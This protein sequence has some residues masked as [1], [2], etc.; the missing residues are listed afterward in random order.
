M[1]FDEQSEQLYLEKLS[2]QI[3][4]IIRDITSKK[5]ARY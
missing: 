1:R 2:R 4:D 3:E 5:R